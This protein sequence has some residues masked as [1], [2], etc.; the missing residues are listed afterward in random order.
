MAFIFIYDF[1]WHVLL[2]HQELPITVQDRLFC[3]GVSPNEKDFVE[4]LSKLPRFEYSEQIVVLKIL[5]GEEKKISFSQIESIIPI[6]QKS[7]LAYQRNYR[8]DLAYKDPNDFGFEKMYQKYLEECLKTDA[9]KS[10][11]LF[12]EHFGLCDF[13]SS[14][15]LED[16]LFKA[17]IDKKLFEKRAR[18]IKKGEYEYFFSVLF[19]FD[20]MPISRPLDFFEYIIACFNLYSGASKSISEI[21][22][23]ARKKGSGVLGLLHD[24]SQINAHMSFNSLFKYLDTLSDDVNNFMNAFEDECSKMKLQGKSLNI[25]VYVLYI[26]YLIQNGF[27]IRQ[28]HEVFKR[29]LSEPN[30]IQEWLMALRINVIYFPYAKI[31]DKLLPEI[32]SH[33]VFKQELSSNDADKLNDADYVLPYLTNSLENSEKER[34]KR[35]EE[36][37]EERK[38]KLEK[39]IKDDKEAYEEEIL[40]LKVTHKHMPNAKNKPKG[41][42]VVSYPRLDILEFWKPKSKTDLRKEQKKK[43]S[44]EFPESS[45]ASSEPS[46]LSDGTLDENDDVILEICELLNDISDANDHKIKQLYTSEMF[47]DRISAKMSWSY[48]LSEVDRFEEFKKVIN[49]ELKKTVN[50]NWR[51]ELRSAVDMVLKGSGVKSV[52]ELSQE[53]WKPIDKQFKSNLTN[54]SKPIDFP[55]RE[56]EYKRIYKEKNT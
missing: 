27:S 23:I 19:V 10:L 12:D 48:E 51:I 41:G 37:K 28:V 6:N 39:Q 26:R 49:V 34:V 55:K 35:E 44:I 5:E 47:K 7:Y 16:E 15:D 36:E 25:S 2:N 31:G 30:E 38:R 22:R 14:N 40:K 45:E 21:I 9:R 53:H 11:K 29:Y 24:E 13:Q 4:V 46:V 8:K 17:K 33:K 56:D 52:D 43:S 3:K 50:S 18:N 42:R 1:E 20:E 54:L 32:N